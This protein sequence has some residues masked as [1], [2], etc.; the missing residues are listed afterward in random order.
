[1]KI[2]QNKFFIVCL[3]VAVVLCAVPSTLSVMGY[4]SLSRNI[5]GTLTQPIRWC[6]SAIGNGFE[7]IVRNFESVSAVHE[8]NERLRQEKE[9]LEKRCNIGGIGSELRKEAFP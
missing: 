7:G 9:A 5:V 8:Q 4:R 3:C 6:F 1:M 2:F